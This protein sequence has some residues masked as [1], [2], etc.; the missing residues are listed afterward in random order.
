MKH[1]VLVWV[2]WYDIV[3]DSIRSMSLI[4]S[5]LEVFM[6]TTLWEDGFNWWLF[7][8]NGVLTAEF[9]Q[10]MF[11]DFLKVDD[12]LV[13]ETIL[14]DLIP[15]MTNSIWSAI[16]VKRFHWRHPLTGQCIIPGRN[17]PKSVDPFVSQWCKKTT[18]KW[19]Y[20][21]GSRCAMARC[22]AFQRVCCSSIL[23][24]IVFRNEIESR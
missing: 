14:E 15:P 17:I 4:G 19:F 16:Q 13:F 22:R 5:I 9:H 20:L 3:I 11:L 6:F 18:N 7:F 2:T 12:P 21:D 23:R 8:M 1:V 24:G 10:M